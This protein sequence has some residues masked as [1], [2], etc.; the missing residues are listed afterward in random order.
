M[1][2]ILIAAIALLSSHLW[3][4]RA[5]FTVESLNGNS[6]V[7]PVMSH[8][9][10][11]NKIVQQNGPSSVSVMGEASISSL[12]RIP[13]VVHIL[14]NTATQNIS[15]DQ[16]KSQ[17]DALNRDFRKRNSDTLNIPERFK[18][19]AADVEI[20]FQLA[21]VDPQGRAS[22][23]IVRKQTQVKEWALD[24]KIKFN[25]QGGDDAWDSKS[26][27]N[28][29]VGSINKTL[30]YSS[31]IN[32]PVEKDGIVISNKV[33][34]TIGITGA[35]NL[36][37]TLV[38]ETGHWLGL[39]HIWGDA[40]CG[41]DEVEDT[42]PQAGFTTGCPTGFRATCGSSDLGDMY[43]NYMDFTSDA[44]MYLFTKGQKEKMRGS[45]LNNGFRYSLLNSKGLNA[46][47]IIDTPVAETTEPNSE[48]IGNS[49]KNTISDVLLYPNPAT[50]GFTLKL[51]DES[52]IGSEIKIMNMN[53]IILQKMRITSLSQL[54]QVTALSQGLYFVLLEKT[55][56]R[57]YLKFMKTAPAH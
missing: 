29:W 42:P 48:T 26:Y 13:V 4:Q 12:I 51:N 2:A 49:V 41:D 16:V 9:K 45:F 54:V 57:T 33:F 23:G 28:I 37:R 44:C 15:D 30:G 18:L 38:H 46:A 7:L 1:R 40:P 8:L 34:G 35:F 6:I 39:K 55:D 47:N 19:L 53:G 32:G 22:N 50:S 3:A 10:I 36:G 17:I 52:W 27:L 21:V 56:K 14:Y 24:D 25:A 5:C 43:M 20:E 31:A 11:A